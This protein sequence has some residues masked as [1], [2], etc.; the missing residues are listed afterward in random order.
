MSGQNTYKKYFL[1]RNSGAQKFGI[2]RRYLKFVYNSVEKFWKI[3]FKFVFVTKNGKLHFQNSAVL[4]EISQKQFAG[5]EVSEILESLILKFN[6]LWPSKNCHL[7]KLVWIISLN[8]LKNPPLQKIVT[9]LVHKFFF[10]TRPVTKRRVSSLIILITVSVL[11]WI[12]APEF[13]FYHKFFVELFG[14][15]IPK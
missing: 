5:V 13:S 12:D 1:Q 8:I 7:K 10:C 2:L 6:L 15:Y 14:V 9:Y 4:P 3:L 11:F